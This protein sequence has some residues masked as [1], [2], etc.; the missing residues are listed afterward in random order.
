[1]ATD[2]PHG[3]MAEQI[4]AAMERVALSILETTWRIED[5]AVCEAAWREIEGQARDDQ[6]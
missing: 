5:Y 6:R 3:V 1:M 2:D 4:R